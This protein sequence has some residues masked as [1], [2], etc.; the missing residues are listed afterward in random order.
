M[1]EGTWEK[2]VKDAPPKKAQPAIEYFLTYGWAIIVIAII[3]AILFVF[4]LAP[5]T[6]VPSSCTFSYGSYCDDVVMSYN[7]VSSS[8]WMLFTNSQSYP[9]L[10]PTIQ[11]NASGIPATAGTCRPNLALAGGAIL[12]S[13]VLPANSVA[14]GQSVSGS[15]Y[16]T[17]TPCQSGNAVVCA[18]SIRQTYSG[19]FTVQTATSPSNTLTITLAEQSPYWQ[20]GSG[21]GDRLTANVRLFGTPLTGA[22]VNFTANSLAVSISPTQIG[23]DGNGNA[24]TSVASSTLGTVTVNAVFANV[25]ATNTIIFQPM[26]TTSTSSISTPTSS[27]SITS[28][29]STSTS[30]T[31]T[32]IVSLAPLDCVLLPSIYCIT[33]SGMYYWSGS[34]TYSDVAPPGT[35][36]G[37]PISCYVSPSLNCITPSGWYL[38]ADPGWTYETSAPSGTVAGSPLSCFIDGQLYCINPSGFYE[39]V[40]GWR[41]NAAAPPGT[42][43]GS[44]LSCIPDAP[45]SEIYCITPSGYEEWTIAESWISSVAPPGVAAGNPLYCFLPSSLYCIT[46][47]GWYLFSDPGWTYETSAPSGTTAGTPLVCFYYSS[48]LYCVNPSGFYEYSAGIFTSIGSAPPGA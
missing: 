40:S 26:P 39:Y 11:L 29:A 9:L 16:L 21:T 36:A 15:M 10:A 35:A 37:S 8:V 45:A 12:C 19:H 41:Y 6:F 7:S 2:I 1:P 20:A 42:A 31:T 3:M 13:V 22:T 48:E 47:S 34:W 5:T 38:Y 43:A 30:A 28:T 44:P 24:Y 27:T 4:I 33:S 46:P 32:T 25:S 23:T 18:N 14:I 17:V